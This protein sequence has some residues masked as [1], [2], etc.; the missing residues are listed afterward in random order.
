MPKIVGPSPV[1]VI[2]EITDQPPDDIAAELYALRSSLDASIPRKILDNNLIV[3]TWNLRAFGSLTQ[4]WK[5]EA[6][7]SPLRDL[8]S[9]LYISEIISRFD[10]IA[11]QEVRGN[12]KCLR[13]MLKYLGSDW[14][15]ILTDV[16]QGKEG[17]DERL[18]FVFDKRKV[19]ISGLACELVVP[20]E[21]LDHIRENALRKQFARTPYAVAFRSLDKTFILVTL[22]IIYGKRAKQRLPEVTAIAEWLNEWASDINAYDHNLIALGDFNIDRAGDDL[23][24]AFISNGLFIH[25]DMHKIPRTVFS[26]PAKP[27]RDKF[28]DQIAWFTGEQKAKALSLEYSKGGY[29][30]FVG[31]TLRD[32]N[33]DLNTH[34]W[35]ISDH[36]PLWVEFNMR[37]TPKPKTESPNPIWLGEQDRFRPR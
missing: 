33:L 27:D 21:K 6:G 26:D 7:D 11:L 37:E 23:Y 24:N 10:V 3:A 36:Y 25:P 17:N 5:S 29:Y 30:D 20:P 9:L 32:R 15:L 18:A 28:Y 22:H 12:L 13:H 14:G 34:T 4:K 2:P 31:S 19:N 16:T 1:N 35:H 8:Q